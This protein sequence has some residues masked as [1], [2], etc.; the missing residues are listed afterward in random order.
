MLEIRFLRNY[1]T[2][3]KGDTVEMWK[4]RAEPLIQ[5]GVAEYV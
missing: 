4:S 1:S 3:K 5:K 2:W